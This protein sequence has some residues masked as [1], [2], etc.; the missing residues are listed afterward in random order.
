MNNKL[1]FPVTSKINEESCVRDFTNDMDN[2]KYVCIYIYIYIDKVGLEDWIT[3][4]E[5]GFE[6]IDG[7]Y[8]DSGLN[9]TIHNVIN[10]LYDLRLNL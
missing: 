6:I 5:A 2:G 7:Y 8:F 1:D 4:H 10:N 3:F 9:N